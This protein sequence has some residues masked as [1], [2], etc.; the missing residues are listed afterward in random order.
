MSRQ[1]R[2]RLGEQVLVNQAS[3]T[4][5]LFLPAIIVALPGQAPLMRH[6][7]V[8]YDDG[9]TAHTAVS[10]CHRDSP[11]FRPW[12]EVL[13]AKAR[14]G[15]RLIEICQHQGLIFGGAACA[16]LPEWAEYMRLDAA[17]SP[18]GSAAFDV[19]PYGY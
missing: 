15:Q 13:L 14:L 18:T 5:P 9:R 8:R 19:H 10:S 12:H 17:L 7:W 3:S 2:F 4:P 11:E 6:L 16:R 1:S